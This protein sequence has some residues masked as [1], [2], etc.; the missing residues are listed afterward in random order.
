MK[1]SKIIIYVLAVSVLL[2]SLWGCAKKEDKPKEESDAK[3]ESNSQSSTDDGQVIKLRETTSEASTKEI[4]AKAGKEAGQNGDE[5]LQKQVEE[6]R[7]TFISLQEACKAND[8]DGYLDFWDYETSML[9]EKKFRGIDIDLDEKRERRRKSLTE[10]PGVLQE[11]ANLKI[12]SITVDTGQAEKMMN[13]S[14]VEIKGTMMLVRT[15][16]RG[17]ALLFHETAKGWKLNKIAPAEY[18]R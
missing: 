17:R 12:E 18:Y 13:F 11:I 16:N 14:G 2:V 8:I 3:S 9:V 5:R 1:I 10:N 4:A 6:V 15:N 7:K